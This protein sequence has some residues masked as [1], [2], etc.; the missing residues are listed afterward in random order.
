MTLA[1]DG[2]EWTVTHDG[3]DWRISWHP[4]PHA[5]PGIPHGS[6]GVCHADGQIVLVSDD[7][8]RWGMPGGR[9]EPGEDWTATLHREVWE[10]ACATVTG[11]LLLGFS[12]GACIR[13]HEQGRVLVRA[14]WQADV[15]LLAWEPAFE[16]THRRLVPA[17]QAPAVVW[18]ED[19]YE[20]MYRRIFAEAARHDRGCGPTIGQ[21]ARP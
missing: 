5:P 14:W 6:A 9:P 3:Q 16:M 8:R 18:M 21:E 20:P 19:G 2:A 4:P 13:G 12:R 15:T 17:D 1:A 11:Q 7:G 10:E